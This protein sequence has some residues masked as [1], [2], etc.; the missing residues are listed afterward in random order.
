MEVANPTYEDG[1]MTFDGF[2]AVDENDDGSFTVSLTEGR[3]IVKVTD[4]NGSIYQVI[5]AKAL[6][7]VVNNLTTPGSELKPGDSYSVVFDTVYHPVNKLSGV[8]NM[9]ARITYSDVEGSDNSLNSTSNQYQVASNEKTQTISS[10][11]PEDYQKDT[12]TLSEGTIYASGFGSP[13]GDH[14]ACLLYT[15]RCV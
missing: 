14:R 12:L 3:N 15:S 7:A 9:S 6:K 11:V 5:T 8:Y 10:V 2:N 4:D 13:F 1:T